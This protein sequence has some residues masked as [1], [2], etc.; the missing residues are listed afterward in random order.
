[1]ATPDDDMLAI[2]RAKLE[3]E[4]RRV[5]VEERKARQSF[6]TRLSIFI[7]A[8]AAVAA[9]A[10]SV[11]LQHV[12]A[13]DDFELKA[14]EIV[15]DATGPYEARARAVALR[16]I[17]P[18]RLGDHFGGAFDPE[19]ATNRATF[20]RDQNVASKKELLNLIAAHPDERSQLIATWKRLFPDDVW[21]RDLEE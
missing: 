6:L 11:Y 19:H 12:K 20:N 10:G 18:D 9:V 21:I 5:R 8:I 2:E 15:M 14:A 4:E 16:E 17:F 7:P 13:K 1:M 3:L